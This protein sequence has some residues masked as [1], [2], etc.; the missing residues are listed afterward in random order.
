MKLKISTKKITPSIIFISCI[1]SASGCLNYKNQWTDGGLGIKLTKQE[2]QTV[3]KAILPKTKTPDAVKKGDILVTV[4]DKEVENSPLAEAYNAL[5]GPVGSYVVITIRRGNELLRYKAERLMNKKF[6]KQRLSLTALSLPSSK[7][8]K[9]EKNKI[10]LQS[11][12]PKTDDQTLTS[13]TITTSPDSDSIITNTN[14]ALQNS[15]SDETD[16]NKT[17]IETDTEPGVATAPK[18]ANKNK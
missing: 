18:P 6:K 11:Q 13:P 5:K 16:N 4:D 7:Q 2:N 10:H 12:K 8:Q 9:T 17:E 15:D 3:I 14:S 1:L